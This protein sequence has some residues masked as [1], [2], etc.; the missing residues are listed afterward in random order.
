MTVKEAIE[1]IKIAIAEAERNYPKDYAVAF[2]MA[3]NALEKEIP[4]KPIPVYSN[5]V[6]FHLISHR[7]P[8]CKC[9]DLGCNEYRF[10][11][12]EECGQNLDWGK[13]E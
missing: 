13:E 11:C 2:D 10:A 9:E 1:L 6:P 3:I 12:C 4:K 7:C 8:A 5:R